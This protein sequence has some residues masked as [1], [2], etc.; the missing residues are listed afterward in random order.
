MKHLN[1]RLDWDRIMDPEAKLPETE[2][3]IFKA[4]DRV[5]TDLSPENLSCDGELS[6]A[7]VRKRARE[8]K[9]EWKELEK[10]FGRRVSESDVWRIVHDLTN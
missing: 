6:G 8:L 7:Q 1:A 2:Q 4:F 5:L 3:E 10:L 9:A